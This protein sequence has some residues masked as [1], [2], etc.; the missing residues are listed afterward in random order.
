[1]PS[2][3]SYPLLNQRLV[4]AQGYLARPWQQFFEALAIRVGEARAMTNLELEARTSTTAATA[5]SNAAAIAD[6][7]VLEAFGAPPTP[8]PPV[9]VEQLFAPPPAPR[10]PLAVEQLFAPPP[11]PR[12][13]VPVEWLFVPPPSRA[14]PPVFEAL[15]A[16]DGPLARD[17]WARVGVLEGEE[18]AGSWTPTLAGAVTAGSHTYTTQA[19]FAWKRGQL[20]YATCRILLSAKDAAM[21]GNVEIRGLPYTSR[22]TANII[23]TWTPSLWSQVTLTANYTSLAGYV[24]PSQTKI[25]LVESGSAQTA[26]ALGSAAIAATTQLIGSVVY[27]AA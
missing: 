24:N 8:R 22:S 5:A 26:L 3:L 7:S 12:P 25:E 13:A 6:A 15:F 20:V 16:D 2:N 21:A 19:G 1:M 10:Q 18:A 4:D 11:V 27:L 17:L 14:L 23:H 9:P